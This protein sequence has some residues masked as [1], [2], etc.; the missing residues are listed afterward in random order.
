MVGPSRFTP[1][2]N[3]LHGAKTFGCSSRVMERPACPCRRPSI[4]LRKCS[5][6]G[7]GSWVLI[8]SFVRATRRLDRSP[9]G[10]LL[11]AVLGIP[12]ALLNIE[13][14]MVVR[15]N[16]HVYRSRTL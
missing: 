16:V 6:G 1:R 13:K 10:G 9:G 11:V 5:W 7:R 8:D 4:K 12:A 15:M 2:T 14:R 3:S